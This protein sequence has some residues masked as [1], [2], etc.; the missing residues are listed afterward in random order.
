MKVTAKQTFF[1]APTG[2]V[3][4]EIL[5][6]ALDIR[7]RFKGINGWMN[8]DGLKSHG[9]SSQSIDESTLVQLFISVPIL[10]VDRLF[11]DERYNTHIRVFPNINCI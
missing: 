7:A 6:T 9:A 4:L 8:M 3:D 11:N 2:R 5:V 1:Q 10:K